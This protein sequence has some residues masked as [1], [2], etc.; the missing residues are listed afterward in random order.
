MKYF[1]TATGT[2]IGKTYVAAKLCAENNWKAL[3]PVECGSDDSVVLGC[4]PLYKFQNPLA[5]NMAAKLEGKEIDF[6]EI[7]DFCKNSDCNII[8]G[9][10]GIMSPITDDKTNL[11]LIRAL[12]LPIILVCG[13]YLGSISHTLTALE[14]L[15]GLKVE[16]ILNESKNSGVDL[17]ETAA[18]I[19]AFSGIKPRLIY[20]GG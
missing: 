11:D 16:V 6:A 17:H 3:K 10:G 14:V 7:I 2:D 5:P 12:D 20:R 4:K 19:E 1:I 9:A 13:S 8:E 15:K 18:Q